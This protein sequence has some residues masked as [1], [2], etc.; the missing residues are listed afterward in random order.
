M[1]N[2]ETLNP[3]LAKVL[4]AQQPS[5]SWNDCRRIIASGQVLVDGECVRNPAARVHASSTVNLTKQPQKP[6]PRRDEEITELKIY[7]VDDHILVLEKPSG[8]ETVPFETKNNETT[9]SKNSAPKTLLDQA[10]KCL[11]RK[12]GRLLPP[13]RVVHR[14]D[15]GTSGVMV[16]ARSRLA[17]RMLGSLFRA[18]D[19]RR[20]YLAVCLGKAR[21]GTIRSSLVPD[22]GDGRRGSSTRRNAGCKIGKEAITHVRVLE[23]KNIGPNRDLSLI[24]CR[25][26]TGRTHQIRIHLAEEG[27]PLAG[28]SVYLSSTAFSDPIKDYSKAPRIA[29]H[30]AELGFKHP[31]TGAELSWTSPLPLDLSTW[32]SIF[33]G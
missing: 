1:Q 8:I 23:T 15:K 2:Q 26:E 3:T 31:V 33:R 13:L 28:E 16:F 12:E 21:S 9:A 20:S 19:I 6:I 4:R 24:E 30:A 25:L 32:Y 10:R 7:H 27:F 17:E 18:H 11:E 29:L 5:W 14:L 22:R